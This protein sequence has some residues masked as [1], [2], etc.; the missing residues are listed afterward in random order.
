MVP[1][2]FRA[3]IV[4]RPHKRIRHV[5]KSNEKLKRLLGGQSSVCVCGVSVR[6]VPAGTACVGLYQHACL[7]VFLLGCLFVIVRDDHPPTF[8]EPNSTT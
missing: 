4:G 3:R 5:L 7:L 2:G 6:R 1:Q 8:L